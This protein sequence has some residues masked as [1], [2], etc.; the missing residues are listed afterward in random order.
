[1][2]FNRILFLSCVFLSLCINAQNEVCVNPMSNNIDP[3]E[4]LNT[5]NKCLIE[6]EN[7]SSDTH[8]TPNRNRYLRKRTN[9]YLLKIR[10]SLSIVDAKQNANKNAES[11]YVS[12][13]MVTQ[14]PVLLLPDNNANYQGNLKTILKKYV[15]DH[16]IYQQE[17]TDKGLEGTVWTSFV[18]DTNGNITNVVTAGPIGA[19]LLEKQA[20]KL[21]QSLP[22]FSPG[23]I[24]D[25]AVNVQHLMTID[26]SV[27][28]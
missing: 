9:S 8:V 15:N 21:I 28:E 3:Y 2:I 10:E 27:T 4:H 20:E 13:K 7:T 5:I 26:F 17:A 12:L 24:K 11:T 18:I 25:Q 23:K 14:E 22:K 1:M 16:I 6:N 19:E